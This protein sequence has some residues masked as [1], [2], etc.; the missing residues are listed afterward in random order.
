[1]TSLPLFSRVL[2]PAQCGGMTG[3]GIAVMMLMV[4]VA[5]IVQQGLHISVLRSEV[6]SVR[7]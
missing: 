2:K 7:R 1:M 6:L 3:D 4:S 5:V